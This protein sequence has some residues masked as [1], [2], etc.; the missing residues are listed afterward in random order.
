MTVSLGDHYVK[1]KQKSV[2]NEFEL[3]NEVMLLGELITL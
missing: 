3:S 2:R 1:T